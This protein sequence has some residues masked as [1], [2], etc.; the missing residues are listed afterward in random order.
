MEIIN[1]E[2]VMSEEEVNEVVEQQCEKEGKEDCPKLV[3]LK[4]RYQHIG[5]VYQ[6]LSQGLFLGNH[7]EAIKDGMECMDKLY[8]ETYKAIKELEGVN[9][10]K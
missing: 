2:K 1:G 5:V 6:L 10:V 9:N 4:E 3:K 8:K 7:C